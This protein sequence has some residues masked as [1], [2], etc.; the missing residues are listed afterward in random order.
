MKMLILV[1]SIVVL[2]IVNLMVGSVPIPLGEVAG[3]LSGRGSDN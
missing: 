1:L 3:I 2:A